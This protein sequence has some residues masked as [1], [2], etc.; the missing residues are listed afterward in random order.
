MIPKHN[1][2]Y[3]THLP[4][5]DELKEGAIIVFEMPSF[6]SG[7]YMAPVYFDTD[8]DPYINKELDYMNGCRNWQI[9]YRNTKA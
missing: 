2:S 6:V 3:L 4:S 7:D 9:V 1:R 8:G 5:T